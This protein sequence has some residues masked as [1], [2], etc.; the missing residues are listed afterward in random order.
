M[1]DAIPVAEIRRI[2]NAG[3]NSH[4]DTPEFIR[5]SLREFLS[6]AAGDRYGSD[7]SSV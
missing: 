4:V 7:R 1:A 3:H 5:D 6:I 2:P